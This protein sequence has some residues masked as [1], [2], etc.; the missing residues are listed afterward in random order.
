MVTVDDYD[1][2]DVK[3]NCTELTLPLEQNYVITWLSYPSH[4]CSNCPQSS[5]LR[6]VT[7][8]LQAGALPEALI[9][10]AWIPADS[11]KSFQ[12]VIPTKQ[13][14]QVRACPHAAE[15]KYYSTHL[16]GFKTH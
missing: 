13:I 8:V 1:Q 5:A 9:H 2:H 10:S 16:K 12:P 7:E 3:L 4:L 15:K 11:C 14:Q 6:S